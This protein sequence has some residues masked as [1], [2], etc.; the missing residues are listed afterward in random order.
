M[1]SEGKTE[2]KMFENYGREIARQ[3][4]QSREQLKGT[5]LLENITYSVAVL[6]YKENML[7]YFALRYGTLGECYECI[8]VALEYFRHEMD[9]LIPGGSSWQLVET[10]KSIYLTSE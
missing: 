5:N 1:Q 8:N 10:D 3:T 6:M 4:W 7:D 2:L 9:S